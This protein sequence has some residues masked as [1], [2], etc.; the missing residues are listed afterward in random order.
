MIAITDGI[1]LRK[2]KY[3]DSSQIIH[4]FTKHYGLQS[5]ILKGLGRSKGNTAKANLFFPSALMEWNVYYKEERQIKLIKDVHPCYF[6]KHLNEDIVKNCV[7]VFAMEVLHNLLIPDDV[8]PELFDFVKMFLIALDDE[9]PQSVGNYPLFFLVQ[10][11]RL[12]GYQILGEYAPLTPF[13][14]LREGRF[15]NIEESGPLPILADSL[16]IMSAVNA[17]QSLSEIQSLRMSQKH[18]QAILQQF[19][20]FFEMHMPQFRPL[21]SVTILSGILS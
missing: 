2:L 20:A 16:P 19:L 5:Y 13:L 10:T 15:S 21:K 9:S 4:V 6:Y 17:A 8:Q 7:A 18:R 3:G 14:N 1:V 12:T 11:G